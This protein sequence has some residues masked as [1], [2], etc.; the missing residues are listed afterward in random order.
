MTATP[1]PWTAEER[2][3]A[4]EVAEAIMDGAEAEA[5]WWITGPDWIDCEDS[6]LFFRKGDALVAAA[7]PDLLAALSLARSMILSGERMTPRA[8]AEIDGA[9]LKALGRPR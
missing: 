2:I 4:E 8:E 5:G 9:L 1:G 6:G 3:T 7:A